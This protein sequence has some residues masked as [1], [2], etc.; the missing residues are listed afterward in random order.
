MKNSKKT[1]STFERTMK[2]PRRKKEFDER[3]R[4]FLLSEIVLGLMQEADLSVR[5]L[6]REVGVSTSVI[7]EIRSGAREN[8]T[9][10]T[11]LGIIG[12]LG[13]EVTIKKGN[14]TLRLSH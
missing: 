6:A 5:K 9:L 12:A 2:D 7:Q 13:G 1:P 3:Y 8:V 11:F 14:R 10:K 4:E